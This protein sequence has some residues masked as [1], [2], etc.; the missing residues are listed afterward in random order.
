[1]AEFSDKPGYAFNPGP[2]PEASAYLRNK[3]I[4][5]SFSWEDVEPEEHAVQ[6]TVA[7]AMHVDVLEAVKTALQKAIDEGIPLEQFTREL[8]PRLRK[9]GWWG[10][11]ELVDPLTG[12]ARRVQLG[13]PRRLR[14]IYRAN[15]R[16][17]RAVGQWERIQRTKRALPYLVYL[18]GPSERHRPQH[19]AKAGLVLHVDDP[20]WQTWY[21]PNGW[22]CKCHVRQITR[23]EAD[24]RGISDSPDV[25]MR[26]VLNK[27]TGEIKRIPSGIDA[28]WEKNPGLFRQ[29][30]MERF[31]AG[32]LDA[33][34]PA[35]ARAAA[36]DLASS[37]RVRRIY[38]G[39][40]KGGVPI[41]VLPKELVERLGSKSK[42]TLFSDATAMKQKRNHPDLQSSD[43]TRLADLLENGRV[44]TQGKNH[45]GFV[46]RD[47][48]L[49]WIAV[50]KV[51]QDLSELY[52]QTLYRPSTGRY[53][54]RFLKRGKILR[55]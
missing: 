48:D 7:K 10:Q 2:P 33:A 47:Y 16:T 27:R 4:R 37:W 51:T 24:E 43:Y 19:Q 5:P 54:E 53:V 3:G 15:I 30:N 44:V 14:T 45:L 31:L 35:I 12:E 9:L 1:M 13:S 34:D 39:T 18:L 11:K 21:P 46:G 52:L 40:A 38:E 20:L 28:G 49:P 26:D 32:K 23:R 25:P 41:G 29:K 8:K 50:V 55:E 22:N 6:F 17:A 36:K 42:M